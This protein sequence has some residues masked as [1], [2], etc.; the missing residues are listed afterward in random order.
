MFQVKERPKRWETRNKK[1]NIEIKGTPKLNICRW[2]VRVC[3]YNNNKA[4]E[5][6]GDAKNTEP[7]CCVQAKLFLPVEPEGSQN[8][9]W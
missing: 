2:N 4:H 5:T 8:W 3:R 1:P 6:G 7:E 9:K